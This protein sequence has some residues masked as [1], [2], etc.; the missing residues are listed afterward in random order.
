MFPLR[1]MEISLVVS[2]KKTINVVII[3]CNVVHIWCFCKC[4]VFTSQHES[5]MS[6]NL[7][8]IFTVPIKTA[9]LLF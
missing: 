3:L 1:F 7:Q 6:S 5:M 2:C 4:V 8:V 9:G